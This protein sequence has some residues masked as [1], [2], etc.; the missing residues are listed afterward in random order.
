MI[1][2]INI[3]LNDFQLIPSS[4]SLEGRHCDTK[5]GR[6]VSARF[7]EDGPAKAVIFESSPFDCDGW[8][9][10]F[11]FYRTNADSDAYL[12]LWSKDL[13]GKY[14]LLEKLLIPLALAGVQ[15]VQIPNQWHVKENQRLGVHYPKRAKRGIVGF[16]RDLNLLEPN[17]SLKKSTLIDIHDEDISINDSLQVSNDIIASVEAAFSYSGDFSTEFEPQGQ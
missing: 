8:L 9:R 1:S 12:G 14:V 16:T 5:V 11:E 17:E 15:K 2:L 13:L 7:T 6:G 3:Y 10:S 4:N